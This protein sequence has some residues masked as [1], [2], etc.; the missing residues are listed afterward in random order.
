MTVVA[1]LSA[2]VIRR[3]VATLLDGIDLRI[4]EGQ[5]WVVI[6]PNG[7]GKTTLLT[8]LAAQLFP[9]AGTVT[10][11]GATLGRVDV[12]ELRPRIGVAAQT[13]AG[14]IPS[15]EKVIDVVLSAAYGV[16][17]RW[18]ETYEDQDV[19]RATSLLRTWNADH[20]TQR[21]FGTLSEGERKRVEIARALMTDPELLLLDEPSGSLD[22]GGR[23]KLVH[24]LARLCLD[25]DAPTS[26]L[27][28]HHLEEIPTGITHALL[29]NRGQTVAAGPIADTLTD[30]NLSQTYEMPLHLRCDDGRWSARSVG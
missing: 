5:R 1:E 21:T 20:L 4:D 14:R 30:E 23:E 24:S 7:A 27:V 12:F 29:L 13:V 16:L 19:A 25:Q 18:R 6:G 8:L 22:L 28:T 11:L 15:H 26:V 9:S 2:V 17:G 10:L 3:G